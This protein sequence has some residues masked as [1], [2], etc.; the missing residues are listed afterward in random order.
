MA[1]KSGS[2]VSSKKMS[3]LASKVLQQKSSS[4]KA[5]SLAGSVLAQARGK[6]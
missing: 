6:R 5:K 4:K 1:T 3:S 2:K